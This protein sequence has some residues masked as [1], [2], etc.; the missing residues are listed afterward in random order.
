MLKMKNTYKYRL[1]TFILNLLNYFTTPF[2]RLMNPMNLMHPKSSRPSF[3]SF[4]SFFSQPRFDIYQQ[5]STLSHKSIYIVDLEIPGFILF[6][7]K[8]HDMN[9][10]DKKLDFDIERDILTDKVFF[11]V[12]RDDNLQGVKSRD[13][14][15]KKLGLRISL[16]CVIDEVDILVQ[17]IDDPFYGLLDPL[18]QI[19]HPTQEEEEEE[20]YHLDYEYPTDGQLLNIIEEPYD[21]SFLFSSLFVDKK[22]ERAKSDTLHKLQDILQDMKANMY[23]EFISMRRIQRVWREVVANPEFQVCRKRLRYEFEEMEDEFAQRKYKQM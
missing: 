13:R 3:Q 11:W 1:I 16:E 6:M 10:D 18:S 9:D 20:G 17:M 2:S 12:E 15:I 19:L 4:F 8:T 23:R 22:E 14:E 5:Y 7:G 21:H